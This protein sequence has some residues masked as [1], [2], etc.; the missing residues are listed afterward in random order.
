MNELTYPVSTNG[1]NCR[2]VA[3]HTSAGLNQTL[4]KTHTSTTE[5]IM[6]QMT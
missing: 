4:K 1:L 3:K 2:L 6:S 5:N